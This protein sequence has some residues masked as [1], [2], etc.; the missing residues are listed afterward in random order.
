M[1]WI[2]EHSGAQS[3]PRTPG[4]TVGKPEMI[5]F[6]R[7]ALNVC[8]PFCQAAVCRRICRC[9]RASSSFRSLSAWILPYS[10]SA[11]SISI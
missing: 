6:T 4:C 8:S 5:Q 10:E 9:F 7:V 1:A 2:P 11:P 3:E